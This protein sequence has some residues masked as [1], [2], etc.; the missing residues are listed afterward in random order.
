MKP[1]SVSKT[2]L[3]VF[4]IIAFLFF[5]CFR[6]PILCISDKPY[7]NV[8]STLLSVSSYFSDFFEFA[9]VRKENIGDF[10]RQ[11]KEYPIPDVCF[12]ILS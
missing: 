9:M 7:P 6:F 12:I 8:P 4:Q 3:K 1:F 11:F 2:F 5:L 10:R